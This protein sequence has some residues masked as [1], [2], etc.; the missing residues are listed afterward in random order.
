V[1]LDSRP[2]GWRLQQAPFPF[3]QTFI[4][5]LPNRAIPEERANLSRFVKAILAPFDL[6]A[7]EIW[8]E[9]I[10][11]EPNELIWYLKGLGI[12]TDEGA[13]NHA[14]LR[15]ENS[16]EVH[17]LLECVLGQWTDFAFFGTDKNLAIYADHDAYTTIFAAQSEAV[18]LL[19]VAIELEGFKE[20]SGW[21]WVESRTA[22]TNKEI[23][24]D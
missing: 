22:S 18:D 5:P 24:N 16:I 10:I 3:Q 7:C 12:T 4:T 23:V 17:D 6:D 11:F 15:A 1:K 2:A 13:L 20:V 8:I 14:V 19:R 9:Q 21:T